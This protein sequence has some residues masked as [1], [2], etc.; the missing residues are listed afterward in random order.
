MFITLTTTYVALTLVY[1]VTI[2]H[3]LKMLGK[4]CRDGMEIQTKSVKKQFVFFLIGF[5]VKTFFY[6]GQ[7]WLYKDAYFAGIF[8]GDVASISWNIAPIVYVLFEHHRTF[9]AQGRKQRKESIETPPCTS[10][11]SLLED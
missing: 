6:T 9:R 4:L 11:A 1:V 3:L 7:L 2:M 5:V 10:N 8:I